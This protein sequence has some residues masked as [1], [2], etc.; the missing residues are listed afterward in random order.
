MNSSRRSTLKGIA[1]TLAFLSFRSEARN[2]HSQIGSTSDSTN[3][4][5]Q[6]MQS[7]MQTQTRTDPQN[8]GAPTKP[9]YVGRFAD[10]TYFLLSDIG[11]KDTSARISSN[12]RAVDVP[13]G[14]VTDFAS[15][16]RI[17]WSALRPDG[18]YAYA[19]IIHD[20]LYW[21]QTITRKESDRILRMCM[22]DFAVPA[23]TI[24]IIYR[25]VRFGGEAA[26]R[27]NQSLRESGEKRILV[28]F[29]TDPTTRW[30]DWKKECSHFG[31]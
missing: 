10:P 16:P 8:D 25:A 30:S 7:W 19:A 24:E 23:K 28:E 1:L 5:D 22:R 21:T 9:L 14:F 20:F 3:Y 31:L 12:A 27:N 11:W 18:L 17:F 2:T 15:I 13:K 4:A 26:W 29:P 6:W